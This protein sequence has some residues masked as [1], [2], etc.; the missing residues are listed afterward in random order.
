M[1]YC[2]KCHQELSEQIP[3]FCNKCGQDLRH[4]ETISGPDPAAGSAAQ[5]SEP[6]ADGAYGGNKT[7]ATVFAVTLT[8]SLILMAVI[9]VGILMKRKSGDSGN[10]NAAMASS[11]K[12]KVT[13][14]GISVAEKPDKTSYYVGEV[15]DTAGMKLTV[16]YSDG[17]SKAVTDGFSCSPQELH[18]SGT[19]TITVSYEGETTSFPVTVSE[20]TVSGISVATYPYTRA[21]FVGDYL[22]TTGLSLEVEYSNGTGEIVSDG[23]SCTPNFLDS[24]GTQTITVSYEGRTA[25]FQVDVSEI[26]VSGIFIASYP[27][28]TTYYVGDYLD[29]TGLSLE[30]E[31]SNGTCEVVSDGFSCSPEYLDGSGTQ[32]I[33]VYYGGQTTEYTVT[34]KPK[35]VTYEYVYSEWTEASVS[36]SLDSGES[37]GG[38]VQELYTP[39]IDCVSITINTEISNLTDGN[40][41]GQWGFYIRDLNGRWKLAGVYYLDSFSESNTITFSSPESFDAWTCP[42]HCLGDSWSFSYSIWLSDAVCFNPD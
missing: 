35:Y 12:E 2:P 23:F 13:V 34:V 19:Q 28:T 36:F 31:Y 10:K 1:R 33:T 39:L 9:G 42:C 4:V 6:A 40:V 27:Y 41:I 30:V 17:T 24:S 29:T 8:V 22:D 7:L 38:N 14:S 3:L 5:P 26:T 20:V 32:T 11:V 37:V 15:L 18:T 16:R 25:T 21:Y